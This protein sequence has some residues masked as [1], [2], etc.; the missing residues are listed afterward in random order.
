[1]YYVLQSPVRLPPQASQASWIEAPE[2]ALAREFHKKVYR[3]FD[4]TFGLRNDCAPLEI[5]DYISVMLN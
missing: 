4:E 5:A 3:H 1:M 2:H